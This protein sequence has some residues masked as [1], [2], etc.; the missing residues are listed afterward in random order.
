MTPLTRT[1]L[2]KEMA[3]H[4]RRK[5]LREQAEPHSARK[6]PAFGKETNYG[7]KWRRNLAGPDDYEP[8]VDWNDA[9]RWGPL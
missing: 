3:A 5:W 9:H 7:S 6:V 8:P 1:E 4:L 2:A